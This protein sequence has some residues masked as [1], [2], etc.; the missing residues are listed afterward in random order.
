MVSVGKFLKIEICEDSKSKEVVML[1]FIAFLTS[2]TILSSKTIGKIKTNNSRKKSVKNKA[3]SIF[4]KF[5]LFI[6]V[7]QWFGVISFDEKTTD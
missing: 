2:L 3:R 5:S 6:V 7:M 4:F 1:S